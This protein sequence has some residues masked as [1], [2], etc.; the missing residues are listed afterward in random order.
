MLRY[1][2]FQTRKKELRITGYQGKTP[3]RALQVFQ[4][5]TLGISS[6]R[7]HRFGK[8]SQMRNQKK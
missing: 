1:L 8:S 2:R 5:S 6:G 3:S 7:P 4:Y